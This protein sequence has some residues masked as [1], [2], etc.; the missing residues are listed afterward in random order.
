ML[1]TFMTTYNEAVSECIPTMRAK[2]YA[3]AALHNYVPLDNEAVS[4]IK[5]KHRS[6]QMYMETRDEGKHRKYTKTRNQVK[7]TVRRAKIKMEQDI[8]LNIKKNPK[9]I[10]ALCKFKKKNPVW[11]LRTKAAD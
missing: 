5:K 9:K 11:Y 2:N 10:L 7:N 8:A 6:W 1:E 3:K 4:K